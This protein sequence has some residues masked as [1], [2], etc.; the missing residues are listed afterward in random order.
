MLTAPRDGIKWGDRKLATNI[1]VLSRSWMVFSNTLLILGRLTK[2]KD[3]IVIFVSL[4]SP[5][6][7]RFVTH[8]FQPLSLLQLRGMLGCKCKLKSRRSFV[9]QVRAGRRL[10][11]ALT[12]NKH[13]EIDCIPGSSV[14]E[15][16]TMLNSA[17]RFTK[18]TET[19]EW[20]QM[21]LR[22][23]RNPCLKNWN[24][25]SWADDGQ[26]IWTSRDWFIKLMTAIWYTETRNNV[27]QSYNDI[28]TETQSLTCSLLTIDLPL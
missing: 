5:N 28:A 20:S 27:I 2:A 17:C 8:L 16:L 13:A 14:W 24:F 15:S 26:G 7:L 10:R 19:V 3:N 25:S 18:T 12:T 11:K 21:Y 22:F 4:R 1:S 9:A 23:T 6:K